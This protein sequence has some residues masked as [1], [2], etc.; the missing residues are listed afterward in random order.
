MGRIK[1]ALAAQFIT[2]LGLVQAQVSLSSFPSGTYF[3]EF[4]TLATS[5][6]ANSWANDSTLAGWYLAQSLPSSPTIPATYRATAGTDATGAI[7]SYGTGISTERALG[8]VAS[9]TPGNFGYGLR[10]LNDSTFSYSEILVSYTGEQWRKANNAAAQ[11]LSFGYKIGTGLTNPL[12]S[13]FTS[14]SG[15]NFNSPIASATT[16]TALDGNATP[17][18]TVIS[19]VVTF[20]NGT[21]FDPGEELMLRWVDVDD[22]STDHGLAIDNLSV[23]VP[24]ASAAALIPLA[25]LAVMGYGWHRRRSAGRL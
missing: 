3:Q 23:A 6:T 1:L 7:Y 11:S 24:E 9:G 22:S 16:A 17:N 8:S 15:L 13:G 20:E 5:G 14:A 25:G 2:G 18:R 21:T 12:D 10:L 4:D 19:L